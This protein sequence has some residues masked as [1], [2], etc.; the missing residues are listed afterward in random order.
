[1]KA[2]RS[3]LPLTKR[4]PH[5]NP[6]SLS[7]CLL[8]AILA[9]AITARPIAG[10]TSREATTQAQEKDDARPLT[11]GKTFRRELRGGHSHSFQ[12]NVE[13][14]QYARVEVEQKRIDIVVSLFAPNGELIVDMDTNDG[15]LW[16]EAASCVGEKGGSYRVEIKAEGTAADKGSYTLKL[17]EVRSS[18]PDDQKRL[19]AEKHLSAGRK[20]FLQGNEN[21]KAALEYKAALDLWRELNDTEWQGVA[22]TSLGWTYNRL[23]NNDESIKAHLEAINLFQRTKDRE[24]EAKAENGLGISY[25]ARSQ[26]KKA[27]ESYEKA[28]VIRREIGDRRG[29]GNTLT[30]LGFVCD[31]LAQYEKAKGYYKRSLSMLR[32]IHD[33]V[34]EGW[35]L[36]NLGDLYYSLAQ[37]EKAGNYF[38]QS[39]VKFR[40]TSIHM[41]EGWSLKGLGD[42]YYKLAQYEKAKDYYERSL[43]IRR[44]LTDPL[45][46]SWTLMALGGVYDRLE[47]HDEAKDYYEKAL[48]ISRKIQDRAGEATNYWHLMLLSEELDEAQL[49]IFYGKLAV[50]IY[51]EIRGNILDKEAQRS[52]L[53][54]VEDTYRN[55][56]DLLI[57]QGRLPEAQFVLGLLK[58]EEYFEFVRR[59]KE[60]ITALSKSVDLNETERKSF[61]EYAKVADE[62][63]DIGS[64]YQPLFD[65]RAKLSGEPLPDAGEEADF[66]KFSQQLALSSNAF[67]KFLEHLAAEFAKANP[68]FPEEI[69]RIK[70]LQSDLRVIG[71]DVVL[72]STFV[73]PDRY[74]VIVTTGETQVDH[75]TEIKAADL[76]R[77]LTCFLLALNNPRIDPRPL[78]KDLYDILVKPL[79]GDLERGK[80]TTILWSLDGALRYIPVAALWDGQHYLAERYQ[81]AIITLGRNSRLFKEVNRDWRVLG[82][83]VSAKWPGFAELPAVKNE[84][85]SIVRDERFTT[86]TEGVLPGRRLVDGDFDVTRLKNLLPSQEQGRSLNLIH[87]ASHFKLRQTLDTSFLLLGDGTELTLTEFD[88]DPRLKMTGVELLTLSACETGVG[89]D[90]GDGSEFEGFGMLAE[91]N[92]AKAVL[93]TLWAVADCS[94]GEFMREF[95]GAYRRAQPQGITKAAALQQAQQAMLS[96]KVKAPT[97][98][99]THTVRAAAPDVCA[100]PAFSP[101]PTRPFAH[102]YYWAPFVLFGNWR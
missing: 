93:A 99:Q 52:F 94:T 70:D 48:I 20:F 9:G 8:A 12:F 71:P 90:N 51:Q 31:R 57:E 45:G 11:P 78:G 73:L 54:S 26:Y 72:V 4:R 65:K 49:A 21:E 3:Q 68:I 92:G 2:G 18:V 7:F 53:G 6:L 10:Q 80:F 63:T 64:K 37:Y 23:S 25:S 32:E 17:A 22:L 67:H 101:D 100:M 81:N 89:I 30:G 16:R 55:L 19:E 87:F 28:L 58:E 39:L 74:R 75:K 84:L 77:K 38:G 43:E 41:G 61:A 83:G 34:G 47:Q 76:N 1:M 15:R 85:R 96:G 50:N 35:V 44:G 14:G 95:Y 29:E 60:E 36:N 98:C 97:G 62:L 33:H 27:R 5:S 82:A 40:Q 102:P 13:Y 24:G 46:E 59:D 91:K 66:Q 69:A 88:T 86:E 42:V 56:A 79:D